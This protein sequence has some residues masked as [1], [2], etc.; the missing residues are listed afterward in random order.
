[1]AGTRQHIEIPMLELNFEPY[2]ALATERLELR[3]ITAADAPALFRLR[4][5]PQVMAHLDRPMAQTEDDAARLIAQ[6][7]ESRQQNT[8]IAW[9][10]SL[11][12]D[13]CLIGTIGFWRIAK[14]HYRAEVGYLLAADFQRRGIMRE[15]LREVID[16]GFGPMGLHSIEANVNPAN[17]ASIRLLENCGFVREAYFRENYFWNGKFLDSAIYSLLGS[18]WPR[19][20]GE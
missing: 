18:N 8:G 20:A 16:F 10:I 14:E 9:A 12:P 3:Q 11:R 19:R 15:A 5:C 17:I 2:P 7:E 4:S 13:P 1:M 6:M